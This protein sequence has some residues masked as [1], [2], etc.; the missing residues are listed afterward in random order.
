MAMQDVVG[1][2]DT[3]QFTIFSNEATAGFVQHRFCVRR[4]FVLRL[5]L[6]AISEFRFFVSSLV[7]KIPPERKAVV[8]QTV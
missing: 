2:G 4:G 1:R 8:R 6:F 7:L 5:T 3:L